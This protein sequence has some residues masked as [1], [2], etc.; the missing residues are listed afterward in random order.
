MIIYVFFNKI[1]MV[2]IE[3]FFLAMRARAQRIII[4]DRTQV[5][6]VR[7]QNCNTNWARFLPAQQHCVNAKA[8]APRCKPQHHDAFGGAS[9][10]D[11]ASAG[12]RNNAN[13][14]I[15]NSISEEIRP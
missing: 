3:R 1:G 15:S 7:P 6:G 5:K 11:S 2:D 13:A 14:S 8:P 10:T 4:I 12:I 9:A